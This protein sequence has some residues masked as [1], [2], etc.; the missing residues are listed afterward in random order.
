MDPILKKELMDDLD[1][2]VKRKEFCRRG[3]PGT[4]KSSLVAATA[5]YLKFDIYDLE[6]TRMRSD[7]DL[8]RL[9]T[10]TA[11]RSILVIED[12][13]C[14]IEL[15]DRQFE[16]YNPGDS[17]LTLSGLLNFIDGLWSSYG[18]ERIIIFTTNYKDKLDSA[19]LRPGRMDMH[20]HMSY[21]S[22]SGFKIL[23]SNYLNIKNHCLFTEIEKLIEEVEV[24][25]AE[26]AEELMKGDDVDTVL[27][28]LQG[29]LQRK[30]EMKCE[31]TE[32]ETQA[33]MPKE[34]AQ[35]EDEK[36][37][38]EMENKYSKGKVKNNKRTR[39][40]RGKGRLV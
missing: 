30:K 7:S 1:R 34:V 32:A 38:Q 18:D 28:G 19:L 4:G 14:T 8:T 36:E 3:P 39:A 22:P 16:H 6:L 17:Q 20:I 2:F 26:I 5:N 31:K 11:N 21:C 25:P 9:L 24:T 23:A 12:I 27:N 15:Q 33:E 10:T 35:N 40:K 13:D 29:F 37:R